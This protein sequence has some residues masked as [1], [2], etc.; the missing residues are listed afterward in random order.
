V[1]RHRFAGLVDDPKIETP[2]TEKIIVPQIVGTLYVPTCRGL[3]VDPIGLDHEA[4]QEMKELLDEAMK[5]RRPPEDLLKR[6]AIAQRKF[7]HPV[8]GRLTELLRDHTC[9]DE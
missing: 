1:T 8:F 2:P 5:Y 6:L 4:F 9:D 3:I 7:L